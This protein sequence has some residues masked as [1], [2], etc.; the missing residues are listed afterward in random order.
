MF[1]ILQGNSPDIM[2]DDYEK[3]LR[4]SKVYDLSLDVI[5]KF[6]NELDLK[7]FKK[8]SIFVEKGEFQRQFFFLRTG[9]A[10]AFI[11]DGKGKEFTVS[12]FTG[13]MPIAPMRAMLTNS[14]TNLIFDCLTDCEIYCGDFLTFF[15]QAKENL[16]TANVYNRML[17]HSYLSMEDRVFELTLD[18]QKKYEKL[19]ERIPQI[20]NLIP[21]YQIA[22]YLNITN[23]QLSRVRKKMLGR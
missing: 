4:V 20:D 19:K 1:Y 21:Q 7:K 11:V 23:V 8:R 15:E 12:L 22:S 5:E 13:G 3:M 16:T 18:A 10:R 6:K 14:K 2:T 17:E 9:I